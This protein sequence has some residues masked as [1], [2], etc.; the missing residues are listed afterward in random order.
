MANVGVGL[1]PQP[2]ASV[3][4]LRQQCRDVAT[5]QDDKQ[6]VARHLGHMPA[7]GHLTVAQQQWAC[8][9][10]TNCALPNLTSVAMGSPSSASAVI[11]GAS[12]RVVLVG[13]LS[14][15]LHNTAAAA[16]AA[17]AIM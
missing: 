4:V 6:P 9:Q 3:H 11:S 12:L 7:P 5:M 13:F 10:L 16:A 14:G 17:A 2:A 15:R 1:G 8:K